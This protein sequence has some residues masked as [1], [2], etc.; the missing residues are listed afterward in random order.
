[1]SKLRTVIDTNVVVSAAL[2][3]NSVPRHAFDAAALHGNLLVSSATIAELDDVLRR[4]KFDKYVAE[5]ERLEFLAALV[6]DAQPVQ[7]KVSIEICS[8]AKDN[9]FLELAVSGNATHI[10][11]GDRGLLSLHP[12]RGIAIVTPQE[13]LSICS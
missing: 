4:P 7:V 8:D 11:T 9:K 1:M 6:A 10:V 12:F 3:P 13:F 5:V 2:L